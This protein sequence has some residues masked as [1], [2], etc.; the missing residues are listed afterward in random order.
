M[1]QIRVPCNL[2]PEVV[3]H[4]MERI[5]EAVLSKNIKQIVV[6]TGA[7]VSVSAGIPDFRSP[8]G[9][10]D[11]L[12]PQLLTATPYQRAEMAED[13]TTVVSWCVWA[14]NSCR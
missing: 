11:T 13:P 12:Q 9:M 5:A 1:K 14:H 8:G 2:L 6:L 4:L 10:Y 7:G 3:L